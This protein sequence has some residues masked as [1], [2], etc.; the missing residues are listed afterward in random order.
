MSCSR[1]WTGWKAVGKSAATTHP[2][3]PAR[4]TMAGDLDQI[5]AERTPPAEPPGVAPTP[6][7]PLSAPPL[8]TARAAV[9]SVCRPAVAVKSGVTSGSKQSTITAVLHRGHRYVQDAAHQSQS[10]SHD[11]PMRSSE[12]TWS[13]MSAEARKTWRNSALP[14]RVV[15]DGRPLNAAAGAVMRRCKW[16]E[17]SVNI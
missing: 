7:P 14:C 13:G 8:S 1:G 12:G 16:R 9:T 15:Y 10:Q 2:W 11:D 3:S 17:Y 6:V 4:L 5:Q